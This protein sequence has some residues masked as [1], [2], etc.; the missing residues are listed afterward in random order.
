MCFLKSSYTE[1][2]TNGDMPYGK[3]A[4]QAST[5]FAAVQYGQIAKGLVGR[6]SLYKTMRRSLLLHLSRADSLSFTLFEKSAQS[7]FKENAN[8]NYMKGNSFRAVRTCPLVM[9]FQCPG[10][11][12][13]WLA[14]SETTPLLQA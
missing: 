12:Q 14:I 8:K 4:E 6:I 5:R 1:N 2:V 11:S 7:M 10:I 9:L 3:T 13:C